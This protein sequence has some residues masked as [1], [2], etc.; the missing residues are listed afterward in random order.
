M[1]KFKGCLCTN[2]WSS[3]YY[4]TVLCRF[5]QKSNNVPKLVLMVWCIGLSIYKFYVWD[6]HPAPVL[7]A[8]WAQSVCCHKPSET[9][10]WKTVTVSCKMFKIQNSKNVP[11]TFL[12]L[13]L[14]SSLNQTET[15]SNRSKLY[16]NVKKVCQ[17][18]SVQERITDLVLLF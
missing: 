16:T 8:V 5:I 12:E 2:F 6:L 11:I 13:I 14:F 10:G 9:P 17:K 1:R 4:C 7:L 18:W 15:S 3:Y